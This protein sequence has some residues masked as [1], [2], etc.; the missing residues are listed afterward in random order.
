M[1][2]VKPDADLDCASNDGLALVT[3]AWDSYVDD[4]G[5]PSAT[6]E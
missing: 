6:G 3:L 2:K 5:E 4:L 1:G